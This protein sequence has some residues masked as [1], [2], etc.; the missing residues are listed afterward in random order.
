MSGFRS[1][2]GQLSKHAGEFESL[3]GQ[4][5]RIADT[6]RRAVD[7][8][9]ACW[10]GDDIGANF[11]RAHCG[12]ADQALDEL[13]AISGRLRDMGAKFSETAETTRQADAGN[14]DRLG[15]LAGRG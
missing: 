14:A 8:A 9:G 5:Q 4:A 12:R 11:A 6:L 15:R 13:G 1:D 3:A 2:L 10:G 7:A